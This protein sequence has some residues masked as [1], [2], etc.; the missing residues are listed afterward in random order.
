[1]TVMTRRLGRS[2][3]EVSALGL[4]CWAI[5]GA[6]AAGDQQLGYAGVDDDLAVQGLHRAVE[7]GITL[8]DTA[9]AYGAGHS[10]RLLGRVLADHPDVLVATKFGN[11]IDEST[12]Q[13]TGVDTS[14]SYVRE[15]L[16]ASLR[17][18]GRDR[19]DLYQ[20]HTPDVDDARA[21]ELVDTLEDLA[22]EGLIGWYGISTDD[23][24]RAEVFAAGPRCT[25]VQLQ[26]N[27]LDDNPDMLDVCE[28]HDLAG[29]CR[30]PLAMGLLGGRYTSASRLP[31]DDIRGR[32]PEWLRWFSDGSPSPEFL[33]RL[34][35]VRHILTAEGRTPAQGALGWIWAHH[36]Q[37]VPLPGFRNPSQVA[38]NVAALDYGPLSKSQHRDIEAILDRLPAG[39]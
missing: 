14:P 21:A 1:M 24:G 11:T 9:D 2:N 31:A 36:P 39:V 32:Q 6:M 4:G 29:L 30:S 18:L 3:L 16:Q 19:V 12:R 17:R 20:L 8:F 26:L 38:E 10:E 15:A 5:G 28:R 25:A 22:A 35:A 7:L 37:T 13:L 27:V 34:D 33:E 23:P